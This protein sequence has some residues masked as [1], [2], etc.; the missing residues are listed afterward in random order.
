MLVLLDQSF[1]MAVAVFGSY[2]EYEEYSRKVPESVPLYLIN[3][4]LSRSR[5]LTYGVF[6]I[7]LCFLD[8]PHDTF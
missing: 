6:K 3:V 2:Q 1:L 7:Y 5:Y 8:F 4:H